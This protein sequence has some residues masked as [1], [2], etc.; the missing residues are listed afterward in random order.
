MYVLPPHH[1]KGTSG[2]TLIHLEPL[3]L[4]VLRIH[5]RRTFSEPLPAT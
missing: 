4:R 5:F 1:L 3:R 2:L